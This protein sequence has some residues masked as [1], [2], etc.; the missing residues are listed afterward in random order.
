[1]PQLGDLPK[2]HAEGGYDKHG[3]FQYINVPAHKVFE[4]GYKRGNPHHFREEYLSQKDHAFKAKVSSTKVNGYSPK[5]IV[6]ISNFN[7]A[8]KYILVE[9]KVA[10]LAI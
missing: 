7:K 4:W 8:E 1:M 9:F 10:I 2:P 6:E 3:E 5:T